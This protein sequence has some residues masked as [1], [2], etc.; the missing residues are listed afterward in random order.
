MDTPTR[1]PKQVN[2]TLNGDLHYALKILAVEENTTLQGLISRL[3][4]EAVA[5]RGASPSDR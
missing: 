2:L 4:A 5:R 3:L 1:P